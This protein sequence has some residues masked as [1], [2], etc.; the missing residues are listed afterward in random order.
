MA[1]FVLESMTDIKVFL[2]FL[3]DNIRYPIDRTTLIDIVAENTGEIIFDYEECLRE[4]TDSGHILA[5][6]VDGEHYYMISDTGHA[7]AVELYDS[8]PADFR[9]QSLRSVARLLSVAR[10]GVHRTSSVSD[11]PDHKFRV[12][13]AA[14]SSRGEIFSFSVTVPTAAEAEK[15][16]ERFAEMPDAVYHGLLVAVTGD[17]HYVL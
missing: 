3:L 7:V 2:L 4:L 9:E 12:S 17:V 10:D 13:L 8:L 6:E 11:T 14:D 1:S 5:D 15:I 16:R